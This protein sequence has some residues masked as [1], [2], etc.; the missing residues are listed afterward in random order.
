VPF[1]RDAGSSEAFCSAPVLCKS[2]LYDGTEILKLITALCDSGT[3]ISA[4]VVNNMLGYFD[5]G[6]GFS[7]TE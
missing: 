5:S 4:M 6:A 2:S 1:R 7:A 3:R